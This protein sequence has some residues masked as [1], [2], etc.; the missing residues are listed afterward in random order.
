[1]IS[2]GAAINRWRLILGKNAQ[3]QL[4]LREGQLLRMDNAL[5]FLYGREEG[6]D[7]K[8]DAQG[9]GGASQLTVARWLSEVRSL[10]PQE[11]AEILQRHALDRYQLT[12]LL[13]DREVLERMEPNQAL[14]ET[15]LSLKHM[16][17]DP[18]LDNARRI[19]QRVAAQ[20]T[21]KMRSDIQRSALGKLDRNSRS[22]LRSARNLDIRRTIQKNLPHYD[23]ENRRLVLEQIYFN[24]RV[25]R[26]NPWRV[27]LAVDESGSMLPSIIHSAVMAGIFARLPMLDTRLV[28]FDTAVVDLSGRVED[29]VETLMSVQLGG[30]TDIAGALRYCESLISAPHRT[31]VVLI[32]DLC[33]GNTRQNLYGV[34]HDILES[35][36]RLVALTALD[37]NAVPAYDRS[38]AEKLAGMGAWVGA[39]T[40][41]KLADFMAVVMRD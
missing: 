34:C 11:T 41:A 23:R 28:I 38:T 40:P 20:L 15:V 5:D 2:D 30:G 18:V 17:K 1:M 16:M 33:E 32:S 14:L 13:T 24:G 29:P 31:M 37:E 36:A 10:F 27:I 35:G 25:R 12:E 6:E 39:M 9:G 21:E 4:P 26:F 8:R 19:V 3:G 22:N 7:V